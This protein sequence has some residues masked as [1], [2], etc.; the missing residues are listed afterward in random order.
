M[1]GGTPIFFGTVTLGALLQ[2]GG[3]L[4]VGVIFVVTLRNNL[5]SLNNRV[6]SLESMHAKMVDAMTTLAVQN[7]RLNNQDRRLAELEQA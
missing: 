4:V 2:I 3:Y 5:Q 1:E 7:E 6:A